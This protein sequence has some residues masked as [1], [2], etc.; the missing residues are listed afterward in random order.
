M[1]PKLF[2][3]S[4]LLLLESDQEEIANK[5]TQATEMCSDDDDHDDGCCG[6]DDYGIDNELD[7]K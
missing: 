5:S 7:I 4:W 6:D 3:S 1:L 2:P